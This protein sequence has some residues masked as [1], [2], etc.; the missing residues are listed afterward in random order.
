MAYTE[1]K[2]N[3]LDVLDKNEEIAQKIYDTLIEDGIV[4]Y[5]EMFG[6]DDYSHFK[7]EYWIRAMGLFKS[8]DEDQQQVFFEIIRQIMVDTGASMLA[9]LDGSASLSEGGAFESEITIDGVNAEY[10]LEYFLS[11][12]E[13]RNE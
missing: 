11:R 9:I 1:D 13:E 7:D 12:D 8:F 10:L 4:S 5:K 2:R 6:I 3:V